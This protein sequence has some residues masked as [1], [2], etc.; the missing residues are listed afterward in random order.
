MA[1]SSAG[2]VPRFARL[3]LHGAA[4]LGSLTAPAR[5]QSIG[6]KGDS[7]GTIVGVVTMKD[8]GLP[9]SYSV[10]SVSALSRERFSDDKGVFVLNDLPVGQTHLRVRH[11]GYSPADVLATVH[12]GQV[13][14]V[15]VQLVHIAVRLSAVEVRAY[16]E[17]KNPGAPSASA[18]AAFATVFDQLHQNADQYR[19]LAN[20]YPYRYEVERTL[21]TTLVNGTVKIE[22]VD[23]I[24]IESAS[25][26]TYRP[27]T[28]ITRSGGSRLFG[29]TLMMN[30][31]TLVHFADPAFIDNHCFYNGGLETVD[32]ADLLRVDFVAASR[33]P[34]PDV[35]GS[36]YLDPA[37]FQI[38]RSVLRLSRIPRGVS[39]LQETEAVTDFREVMAS[40][41][42]IADIA[43]VNRFVANG[44]QPKAPAAAN[45]HQRLILVEFLK[46]KPGDDPRKP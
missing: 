8:G 29:G 30:I 9:L 4:A 27:G 22:T 11:L 20:T 28:V 37:T 14:T 36:M 45:E 2:N 13:D 21:S 16:P 12:A 15:R 1:R 32:G 18:D 6:P 7:T 26:W 17:C 19:L 41:P 23:T 34:E 46:G 44:R 3:L 31:P 40:I 38:R 43:S 39:G 35:N 42:I 5:A 33:I 10:V 25:R 24:G